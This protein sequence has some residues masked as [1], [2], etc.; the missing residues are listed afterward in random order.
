MVSNSECLRTLGLE[1]WFANTRLLVDNNPTMIIHG[2]HDLIYT[3]KK[4]RMIVPLRGDLL[5]RTRLFVDNQQSQGGVG[6]SNENH[7]ASV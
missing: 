6:L 7:G 2:N 5:Q 4:H 1:H 3:F